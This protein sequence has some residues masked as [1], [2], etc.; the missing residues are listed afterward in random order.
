[1]AAAL[2][3][4]SPVPVARAC[5]PVVPSAYVGATFI[6][7]ERAVIIWD[8]PT[9]T[10]HFIRQA[11]I[12]TGSR[13]LGFLVP[14]PEM[15]DFAPVD[16]KLFELAASIGG[17]TR[18]PRVIE[19]TP[20]SILA[21]DGEEVSGHFSNFHDEPA[22]AAGPATP[23]TKSTKPGPVIA[24]Q[25]VAGYHVTILATE[26][27]A[28]IAAW[29]KENDYATSD[30]L[31]AWIKQYGARH[32]KIRAF[33]LRK[34]GTGDDGFITT[35]PVRLSF[36][37]PAPF[38]PYCEP[39]DRQL[40]SAASP[41]GRI[42]RVAVLSNARMTGALGDQRAWPGRLQYA[43]PATAPPHQARE[44]LADAGLDDGKHVA[45]PVL[46][47][48][49]DES[50]PRPGTADLFFT[51]DSLTGDFR[52]VE[53]DATL[54]P[55]HRLAWDEPM[56]VLSGFA[57]MIFVPGA[58]I[59]C[60]LRALAR[61]SQRRMPSEAPAPPWLRAADWAFG[62][63]ALIEGGAILFVALTGGV[64]GVITMMEESTWGDVGL[65]QLMLATPFMFLG[66]ALMHCSLVALHDGEPPARC[67]F[68]FSRG[69]MRKPKQP[70]FSAKN[71]LQVPV[72]RIS[73]PGST[74]R[75]ERLMALASV[76]AGTLALAAFVAAMVYS[77]TI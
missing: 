69:S 46:T 39:A 32:W 17:P 55:V 23:L 68:R 63:L 47:T 27:Y 4:T 42:L 74:P 33:K 10:E 28:A 62:L 2:L 35:P 11:T 56:R 48:F 58:P 61:T 12:A 30:A 75:R 21:S 29:L 7:A 52:A 65:W 71:A 22:P 53:T 24:E 13:D 67:S 20:W 14:T 6:E 51:T 37:T 5:D 31:E 77:G 70:R 41:Y 9:H 3:S 54:P 73:F 15:P 57:F 19:E 45:P 64:I 76:M 50:N 25:D 49:I 59:Y 1:M 36:S 18:V 38:Y 16:P 72:H 66:V 34:A 40:E 44:W 26:D 8:A 60:G 43:G